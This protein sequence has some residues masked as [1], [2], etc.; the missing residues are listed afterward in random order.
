TLQYEPTLVVKNKD[1]QKLINLSSC[2][3]YL[4]LGCAMTAYCNEGKHTK[5]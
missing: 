4:Q 3:H 2:I 1:I 5:F